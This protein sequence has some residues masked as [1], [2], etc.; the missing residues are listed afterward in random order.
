MGRVLKRGGHLV[1][2]TRGNG[3]GE[4]NEPSDY[5]RFMPAS[6]PLLLELAGCDVVSVETDP[7]VPGIFLHGV[8]R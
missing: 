4:H 8:R 5:W 3:F 2:T 1:V 7:E 6:G